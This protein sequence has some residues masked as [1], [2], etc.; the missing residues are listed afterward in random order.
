MS[1]I[2]IEEALI[3]VSDKCNVAC[4]FCF[5][6]DKGKAALTPK[7]LPKILSRLHELG[8]KSVCFT[9]GEPSDHPDFYEFCKIAIQFGIA[10]SV[11]T[12][13]RTPEQVKRIQLASK[14]LSH[15]TVSADSV[16]VRKKFQSNRCIRS[17]ACT[18]S[19]IQG[20]SKSIHLMFSNLD[21]TD[22]LDISECIGGTDIGLEFSP[23]LPASQYAS[24]EELELV[25]NDF[26]KTLETLPNYV[27]LESDLVNFLSQDNVMGTKH[28]KKRR[29]YVSA[30]EDFRFCPYSKS[31]LANVSMSRG[32]LFQRLDEVYLQGQEKHPFCHMVCR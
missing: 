10:P 16:G 11:V 21:N 4:K 19:H 29:I 5:R 18:L 24:R 13:A 14:F 28:C 1:T 30:S 31:G 20:P 26:K 32:E 17:A 22:L 23:M 3:S 15:I 9:G 8:V 2:N 6:S 27:L 25:I 7:R 12:S